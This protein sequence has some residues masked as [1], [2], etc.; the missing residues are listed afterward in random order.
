MGRMITAS[1]GM[2]TPMWRRNAKGELIQIPEPDRNEFVTPPRG[3]RA[4]FQLSGISET[5]EMDG[6]YG[7]TTNARIEFLIEKASGPGLEWLNGKR[8]TQL[9][10][11]KVSS[12]STFGQLLG[13]L[14]GREIQGG[15]DVDADA[16]IGTSFVSS[17]TLK[18]NGDKQY[19]GISI[20]AIDPSKTK[21]SPF[22]TQGAA[23]SA[24]VPAGVAAGDDG[25]DENP[26]EGFEGDDDL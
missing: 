20:E 17:T 24:L 14:R 19:A 4:R 9:V 1:A 22:V 23:Q 3:T 5:F 11:W 7:V 15:E 16:Y 10:T 26:F 25:A 2:V 6:Q 21:L 12:K 18:E 13:T 8:F